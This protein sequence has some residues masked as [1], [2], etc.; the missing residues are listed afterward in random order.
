ME[1]PFDA[2]AELSWQAYRYTAEQM[3]LAEREAFEERLD[4]DQRAREMVAQIVTLTQT[5]GA[6]PSEAFASPLPTQQV[7]LPSR[8]I[9]T[10]PRYVAG[11]WRQPAGW[12]VMGAAACWM[13]LMAWNVFDRDAGGTRLDQSS[14]PIALAWNEYSRSEYSRSDYSRSADSDLR[15]SDDAADPAT[16]EAADDR[17]ARLSESASD[18]ESDLAA[19][20]WLVSAMSLA[21]DPAAT[22]DLPASGAPTKQTQPDQTGNG[23]GGD[24]PE[25]AVDGTAAEG[26]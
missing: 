22:T 2:Q 23:G 18:A 24:A 4:S 7:E 15:P 8:H 1:S 12:M 9:T 5:L 6:M 26:K 16:V 3:S 21:D 25:Q 14:R 13:L 19:P 17:P 20:E 11:G 10:P